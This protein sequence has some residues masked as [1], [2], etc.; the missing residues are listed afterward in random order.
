MTMRKEKDQG[1]L[2][3]SGVTVFMIGVVLLLDNLGIMD[4]AI[5]FPLVPI[6][7]GLSLIIW[8]FSRKK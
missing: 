3:V 7:I 4:T 8:H 6:G 2:L 5:L 1:G